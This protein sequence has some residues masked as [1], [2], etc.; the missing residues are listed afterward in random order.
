MVWKIFPILPR[1]CCS[2]CVCVE[3]SLPYFYVKTNIQCVFLIHCVRVWCYVF[4][5]TPGGA[6]CLTVPLLVI[7]IGGLWWCLGWEDPLEEGKATHSGILAWRI[8]WTVRSRARLSDLHFWCCHP[9]PS[10]FLIG[11]SS[12]SV[13][14]HWWLL[15]GSIVSLGVAKLF[16]RFYQ[17]S[18][19]YYLWF[20]LKEEFSLKLNGLLLFNR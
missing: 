8:P 9:L 7:L 19:I 20:F 17:T 12:K 2:V 18:C 1:W 13:S 3:R 6:W 15:P 4:C 14:S 10:V 11:L 5:I 16:F